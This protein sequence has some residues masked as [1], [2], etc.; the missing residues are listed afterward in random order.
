VSFEGRRISEP[1]ALR[2]LSHPLRLRIIELLEQAGPVTATEAAAHLGTTPSNC[3]FHLRLLA[4]HG[5]IEEADGAV[6]RNRPWK[7]SDPH[8]VVPVDELDADARDT[9]PMLIGA[10]AERLRTNGLRWFAAREGYSQEWRD[11]AGD[12][13]LVLHLTA[14]ELAELRAAINELVAPYRGSGARDRDGAE[15]V[16]LVVSAL[17]LARPPVPSH[18]PSE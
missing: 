3:S 16:A 7:R 17:P 6:G 1:S 11:A 5:F 4:K 18:D 12:T 9:V 13:H 10:G 8:V 14:A 15:P 2:A